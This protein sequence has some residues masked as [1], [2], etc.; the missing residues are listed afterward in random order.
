M[1]CRVTN[2]FSYRIQQTS[3]SKNTGKFS[4]LKLKIHGNHR[5]IIDKSIKDRRDEILRILSKSSE[6]PRG[7]LQSP[8]NRWY[9]IFE[10]VTCQKGRKKG[11]FDSGTTCV[12]MCVECPSGPLL[13]RFEVLFLC[14]RRIPS[15]LA[16]RFDRKIWSHQFGTWDLDESNM[17]KY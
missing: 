8:R 2:N 3:K 14:P 6:H 13:D 4:R 9:N 1:A 5:R 12:C 15:E 17:V 16:L 7:P 11:A 10:R